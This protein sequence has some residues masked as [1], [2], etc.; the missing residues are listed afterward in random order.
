MHALHK[1]GGGPPAPRRAALPLAT[2]YLVILL[3]ANLLLGLLGH[4][5]WKADEPYSFGLVYSIVKGGDWV[6]PTLVG[7]PF[8]EKPPLYYLSAAGLARLLS[9]PLALHDAARVASGLYAALAL[10]FTALAA[11]ATWGKGAGLAAALALIGCFGF[12]GIAHEIITDVAL[13]AGFAIAYFG[14]GIARARPIAAG[15]ALGIGTGMGFMSKGLIAPGMIGTVAVLLPLCFRDWRVG[16]YLR[17]LILA[18]V[19]LA[20]WLLIWPWV[21]YQRSPRLFMDWFWLNNWGRYLGFAGLGA[22]AERWFYADT[23]WWFAWPVWPLVIWTLWRQRERG[24]SFAPLRLPL[25]SVAVIMAI[26]T[27]SASAR[28]LYA[29]PVLV[30]MAVLAAGA[31]DEMPARIQAFLDWGSRLLWGGLSALVWTIWIA[32]VAGKPIELPIL[33][34]YL[35]STFRA[36]AH[37]LP[38][39]LALLLALAWLAAARTLARS[40]LRALT[41]WVLGITLCWG[42]IHTLWSPWLDAAKSYRDV[43]ASMQRSLPD[44]VDC[45]AIQGVGESE[46]AMLEY[47]T[48]MVPRRIEPRPGAACDV[49]LIQDSAA[50]G[51]SG[52]GSGWRL[53]WQ[54]A[55]LGDANERHRLFIRD[56]EAN[57]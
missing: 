13:L 37:P 12:I 47:F 36:S 54:G 1:A 24:L 53:I 18:A 44:G 52:A 33:A 56:V 30:P 35:P 26:L 32:L 42:T 9:P 16:A 57:R 11:R 50:E 27:S 6:V 19:A 39:A 40:G 22:D 38:L 29:L 45:I 28:A 34:Q 55:R 10:L 31:A 20:P 2:P 14:L 49:R 17:S 5:P 3:A 7:E 51:D 21:L 25:L 43:Y 46:R 48:G 15:L 23:L 41:S 4:D 8:M